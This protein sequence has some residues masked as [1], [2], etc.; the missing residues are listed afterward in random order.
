MDTDIDTIIFKKDID[1]VYLMDVKNLI[2]L[3]MLRHKFAQIIC[4][5]EAKICKSRPKEVI[6]NRKNGEFSIEIKK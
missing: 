1:Y 3:K 2:E 4:D 6:I 5:W